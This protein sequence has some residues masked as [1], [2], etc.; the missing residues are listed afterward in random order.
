M[1]PK[2]NGG[3]AYCKI[4]DG[5]TG[6]TIQSDFVSYDT[7][8]LPKVTL[9]L[10]DASICE[11]AAPITLSGGDPA[12]GVYRL[13]GTTITT[14]DPILKGVGTYPILYR[15]TSA[16]NC[17]V[18][19]TENLTVSPSFAPPTITQNGNTL[20]SDIGSGNQ[21]YKNGVLLSGETQ[22]SLT[23]QGSGDYYTIVTDNG[24]SATSNTIG[25]VNGIKQIQSD[26]AEIYLYPNPATD[27]LFIETQGREMEQLSIYDISGKLVLSVKQPSKNG[28]DINLLSK[29]MYTSEIIMK[30]LTVMKK[31]VKL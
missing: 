23:I 20:N 18:S 3:G 10:P 7:F 31:F 6:S 30:K 26:G 8:P 27:R 2:P 1:N 17:V 5:C 11:D 22:A 13:N 15:Y 21:W 14:F 4:K 16:D 9:Q 12:G 29:G 25:V 19:V 24:C 28:I